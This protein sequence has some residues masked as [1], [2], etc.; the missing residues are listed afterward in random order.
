MDQNLRRAA[1]KEG[2]RQIHRALTLGHYRSV[3]RADGSMSFLES[4]HFKDAIS[5]CLPDTVLGRRIADIPDLPASVLEKLGEEQTVSEALKISLPS[6]AQTTGLTLGR[7]P[8][9]GRLLG[10]PP[11]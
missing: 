6:L 8:T 2:L 7:L 1:V 11:R 9:S 3:R 5:Q 4:D 10:I